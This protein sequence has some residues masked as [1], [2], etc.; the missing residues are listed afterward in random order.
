MDSCSPVPRTWRASSQG[1][2]PSNLPKE[3][4][5]L[6][7]VLAWLIQNGGW[8]L[9]S[10]LWQ[11]VMVI[12]YWSPPA[13]RSILLRTKMLWESCKC[14]ALST[15][16]AIASARPLRI[17]SC[18]HVYRPFPNAF[19]HLFK[20]CSKIPFLQNRGHRGLCTIPHSRK[21]DVLGK[22][23]IQGLDEKPDLL[24]LSFQL[25]SSAHFTI[26]SSSSL[27]FWTSLLNTPFKVLSECMIMVD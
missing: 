25:H 10:G 9:A 5:V 16:A 26:H 14:L 23:I 8:Y 15:P 1:P 18:C 3:W 17:C 11:L 21:L 7:E 24:R 13:A 22:H 27:P 2:L 12:V 20:M 4:Y 19:A 6:T